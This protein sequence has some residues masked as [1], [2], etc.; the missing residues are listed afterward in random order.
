[1]KRECYTLCCFEGQTEEA[2][3][4]SRRCL[5]ELVGIIA[6]R[7]CDLR[8]GMRDPRRLVS[9]AAKGYWS[10]IRRIGFDKQT[11]RGYETEQRVVHPFL[12]CHDSAERDKPAGVDRELRERM[13]PGV[14]VQHTDHARGFGLANHRPGVI[15]C[16]AGVNHQRL[17]HFAGQSNLRGE[18]SALRVTRRVVVVV[19]QA[20]LAN[21]HREL[22]GEPQARNVPCRVE[23][24]GV[25]GMNTSSRKDEPRILNRDLGG[26]CRRRERFPDAHDCLRARIA[27]ARDYRVAVAGE[28]RVREVGVAVDED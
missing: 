22:T 5:S 27:G 10:E 8:E 16:V 17:A 13:T 7:A 14:A 9:L 6:A 3:G 2:F 19:V 20:A 18:R 28:R 26:N 12:E 23:R 24:R 4:V 15:F 21:R 11:I 25:V 1:M